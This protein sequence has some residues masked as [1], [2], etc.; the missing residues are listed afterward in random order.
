[1]LRKGN[2]PTLLM[3][4]ENGAAT[5]KT[6]LGVPR[7]IKHRVTMWPS[8]S[9]PW[10]APK[11]DKS[12]CPHRGWYTNVRSSIIHNSQKVEICPHVQS[13]C[14]IHAMESS[15]AVKEWNPDTW[16]KIDEPWVHYCQ[17][18]ETSHKRPHIIRFLWKEMSTTSG[19]ST[20]T[21]NRLVVA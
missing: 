14:R 21:G 20:E 18:K 5:L 11:R 13:A 8:N 16:Y 6:S 2:P 17:M 7:I 15:S 12:I 3:G 9:M 19:K 1:M 4:M 10:Y